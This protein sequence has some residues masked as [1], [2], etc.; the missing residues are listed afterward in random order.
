[1]GADLFE[2]Y[3]GSLVSALTLGVGVAA[4]EGVLFPLAIS[5]CGLIA[6]II[7]T[8]FVKGDENSNPQKALTRGSYVSAALVIIVSLHL[9]GHYLET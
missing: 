2:S 5:G 3:V 1:M 9:A 6:S 4:T 8:F 7:A